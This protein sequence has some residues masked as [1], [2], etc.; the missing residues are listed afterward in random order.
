MYIYIN[1]SFILKTFELYK[2]IPTY[3]FLHKYYNTISNI[4]IKQSNYILN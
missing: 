3:T 1:I 4:F 2:V